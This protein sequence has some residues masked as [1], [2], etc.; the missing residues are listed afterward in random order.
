[1]VLGII[2]KE[3]WSCR[4][5]CRW[6]YLLSSPGEL[7]NQFR[8]A[9]AVDKREKLMMDI[10]LAGRL[11]ERNGPEL[12]MGHYSKICSHIAPRKC[13]CGTILNS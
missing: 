3:G 6:K 4:V 13:R 1:M 7:R 12:A 8:M 2:L 5:L 10:Y 11:H 9:G